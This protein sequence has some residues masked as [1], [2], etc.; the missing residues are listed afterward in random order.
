MSRMLCREQLLRRWCIRGYI[1]I[2]DLSYAYD[3]DMDL[4]LL[5]KKLS[6]V[7]VKSFE[8]IFRQ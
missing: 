8:L 5:D 1:V 3:Y 2:V 4:L 7:I 6:I